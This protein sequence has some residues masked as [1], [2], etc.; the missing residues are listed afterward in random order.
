MAEG[1]PVLGICGW[2]G[3][4]KTTLVEQL[5]GV[6]ASRGLKVAAV[7][8]GVHGLEIDRRMTSHRPLGNDDRLLYP[9]QRP[10]GLVLGS[11]RG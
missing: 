7:K 9:E 6:L 4:G 11:L 2:G 5:I 3:S 1:L 10:I 8:H